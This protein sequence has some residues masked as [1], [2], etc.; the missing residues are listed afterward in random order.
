MHYFSPVP[1][2]P[3]LEI[4]THKGTSPEVAA[5]AMAVGSRQGKT[6]IF[7]KDVPGFYVNRCLAP[8]MT[9]VVGLVKEGVDLMELDKA[10][11]DFGMPVGP[12]TLC[13][14][15]GIDISYHVAAFMSK[16]DLGVRM[17][18]GDP[19][20][21]KNMIEKGMS[22]RKSGKGFYL[23]PKDAKKGA[24]KQLNPEML[25]MLK[26]ITQSKG[27]KI[28]KEDM[29]NRTISRFV[30]EAAF[31]LQDGIIRAPADGDIGAV[32]GIGFPPF[33]GGPFR[34]L[35]IKGTSKFVDQMLRYRDQK[36]L[37]FEPCQLLKDYAKSGKKF[38]E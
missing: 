7:V 1:M 36:G 9:E 23:Y 18:G 35:D 27:E 25:S 33:L 22:G 19:A 14:E 26:E 13:D 4:I 15:V 16:A 2:M 8:F 28:S 38:H 11:K 3:L 12:I 34:M 21:L 31:C 37:Q 6:P 29:Q 20:F 24:A 30:N 5:S 17:E 32:F 10:L